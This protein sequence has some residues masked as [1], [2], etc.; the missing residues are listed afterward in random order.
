MRAVSPRGE[1]PMLIPLPKYFSLR[2]GVEPADLEAAVRAMRC[3]RSQLSQQLMDRLSSGAA[4]TLPD[5]VLLAPAVPMTTPDR[6]F[7]EDRRP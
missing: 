1:Q 4:H 2:I 7:P 3:H 5:H 6:L